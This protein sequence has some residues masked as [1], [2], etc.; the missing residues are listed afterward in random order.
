[1]KVMNKTL[2]FLAIPV[3]A[4]LGAAAY[5]VVSPAAHAVPVPLITPVTTVAPTTINKPLTPS[6]EKVDTAEA[7]EAASKKTDNLNEPN[8]EQTGQNDTAD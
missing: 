6:S 5:M 1:M 4:G 3:V 8:I 2:G 7:P